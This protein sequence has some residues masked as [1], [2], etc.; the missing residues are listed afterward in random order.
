MKCRHCAAELKLDFCDLGFSPPSNAY[1]SAADLSRPEV[2]YPLRVKVCEN[3]WLVQ[4]ED[5]AKHDELFSA[6][7]AYFSSTSTS[8]LA[9]AKAYVDM[10]VPRLGLG[11]KSLVV[12]IASNDGYLLQYVDQKGIPCLGV[13][14]T[15]STAEA[16]RK[17]GLRVESPFF[18]AESAR[19]L[20]EKY[21]HADL[22]AG[23]N[24]LAHVPDINDFLTGMHIL[25]A[26]Q[27][28][29]TVEFPHLLRLIVEHQF[30]TIYHEHF[31]YLSL[32]AVARVFEHVG[33][34]VYDVEKLPTHGGSLRV[35]ACQ[36]EAD[37]QTRPAVAALLAEEK[38][39][40]LDSAA[41]YEGFQA[42]ADAVRFG[43]T[44][45]LLEQ[46]LAGKT[47]MGYGAAAKG[48]TLLNYAGID[49]K[50]LPMVADAAPS[51]QNKFLPGSHIPIVTPETLV[52]AKP[53]FV[54]ILPWNLKKEVTESMKVIR[55]WGGKFVVAVPALEVW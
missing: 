14:P 40:K 43:L 47:V 42:E 28:T 17:L 34:R 41:G 9:H 26:P 52:A 4:T 54:V 21:G 23:N 27:G 29:V 32:L 11:A 3:C 35:Y 6:D 44:A 1:L 5:F 46:R 20:L 24:V 38:A 12:E 2:T 25:L 31:S 45:F 10:I 55:E 16:A 15:A 8:W 13:E 30:D 36:K 37:L 18:G 33:M 39:A 19:M 48:C 51:K 53:D 49:G 22:I 7:Y 50:L